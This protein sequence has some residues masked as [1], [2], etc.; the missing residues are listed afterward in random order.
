MKSEVIESF[1]EQF[2]REF[3][4]F[5][6]C[7][8]VSASILRDK[9]SESGIRA[10]VSSR[11]KNPQRLRDKIY[12]RNQKKK[13]KSV[14]SIRDDIVDLSGVRVAL[15]FPTDIE[16][17]AQ[18]IHE[19]HTVECEVIFP[20]RKNKKKE[21][22]RFD[23]YHASH[24]RAK[25][26]PFAEIEQRLCE[27]RI[28]IQ[29]ASL[30]MHAWAEV[31]HDLDYKPIGGNLGNEESMILDELNGLVIAGEIALTRLHGAIADR[32]TS[33]NHS[34]FHNK[35]ELASYVYKQ[36]DKAGQASQSLPFIDKLWQD[37]S[38]WTAEEKTKFTTKLQEA[39]EA[40]GSFSSKVELLKRALFGDEMQVDR[41]NLRRFFADA[42]KNISPH[43]AAKI[44][45]MK[46]LSN[47]DA[48]DLFLRNKRSNSELQWYLDK[49]FN[50]S[51]N[52]DF[53][54]TSKTIAK[55][56]GRIQDSMRH[57]IK[58]LTNY[59][60]SQLWKA[61]KL[62]SNKNPETISRVSDYRSVR[63]SLERIFL[64]VANP[65]LPFN[66]SEPAG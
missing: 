19:T 40:D 47:Y 60:V 2:S 39:A 27:A 30:L 26:S 33:N 9:I 43:E 11:A 48:K 22:K 24:F 4:Y 51:L 25:I 13:Y 61:A 14:D 49:I 64:K 20:D 21:G 65:E 29:V 56:I 6:R 41:D 8:E 32:V 16:K 46:K 1:L 52:K 17:I 55:D 44:L 3:E 42:V 66:S 23:G 38:T 53:D 15:Y 50:I 45:A 57:R 31:E 58:P 35:Y 36:L 5:S 34:A 28:E 59:E 7:A 54:P 12:A 63:N 10:I 62:C 18:I 37:Y